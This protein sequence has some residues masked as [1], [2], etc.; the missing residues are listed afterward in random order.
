MSRISQ[1]LIKKILVIGVL[2]SFA[3]NALSLPVPIGFRR[4]PYHRQSFAMS[5]KN[6]V[7]ASKNLSNR[8]GRKVRRAVTND[9][10]ESYLIKCF[11]DLFRVD[12]QFLSPRFVVGDFN[13]DKTEDVFVSARLHRKVSK[14]DKSQ[15][16][17]TFQELLD[18]YSP[19]SESLD[20]RMGNLAIFEGGP[21][22]VVL[23]GFRTGKCP[24]KPARF[25]LL[26]PINADA[27]MIK[28]YGG[29]K[30]PPG[31]T[32]DP[33][34]DEPP[35]RLKGDAILIVAPDG[36]GTAIYWDGS[37]YRWYPYNPMF[38]RSN[39]VSLH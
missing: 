14:E 6:A 25:V 11:G 10:V 34:E 20:L 21:W 1:D 2:I 37:R 32:G 24:A 28:L 17:F 23:H 27:T 33:K 31:T 30:L 38:Q 22:L 9:D 29:E 16:P 3:E 13:G 5:S 26:F 19:A 12:S 15:P 8:I 39:E 36:E 4:Q 35:P 7:R 18:A